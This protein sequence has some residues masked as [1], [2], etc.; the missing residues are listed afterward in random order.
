[1]EVVSGEN[2]SPYSH[3]RETFGARPHG[4]EITMKLLVILVAL[5]ILMT[6]GILRVCRRLYVRRIEFAYQELGDL[7]YKVLHLPDG[8]VLDVSPD[9]A[10]CRAEDYQDVVSSGL[11][12]SDDPML[13][14]LKS[15]CTWLHDPD[16]FRMMF[17]S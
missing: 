2:V 15:R 1:M 12:P 7:A 3:A 17:P 16:H 9:Y 4:G 11:Y 6:I 5:A 14:T 8:H 10:R 13:R